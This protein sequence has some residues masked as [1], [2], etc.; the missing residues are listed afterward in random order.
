MVSN[1]QH[2]GFSPQSEDDLPDL[3]EQLV[4]DAT[5]RVVAEGGDYRIWRSATGA[6]VWLYVEGSRRADGGLDAARITGLQ[7]YFDPQSRCS[8]RIDRLLRRPGEPRFVGS[9]VGR[10]AGDRADA[11]AST[12]VVLDAVDFDAPRAHGPGATCSVQ[13]VAFARSLTAY[14]DES[15]FHTAGAE[16][17]GLSPSSFS[18]TGL[19]AGPVMPSSHALITGAVVR[20]AR[21][22]NE[23]SGLP[24]DHI[25]VD[26]PHG[27]AD[28]VM[29][30][31][32]IPA[33][34][35]PGAIVSAM[36]WMVGR[37]LGDH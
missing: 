5:A 36:C 3:V 4:D 20:H 24:F 28:I 32:R 37:F 31:R 12:P 26:C 15:A 33:A 17:A 1:L 25:T 13:V 18:A 19:M 6:E 34:V 10:F 35:R 2:I 9:I 7:A 27:P 30:S 11:A 29:D 14:A 22:L 16:T 23:I 8:V 21:H